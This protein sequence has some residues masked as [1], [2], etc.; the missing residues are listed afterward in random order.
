MTVAAAQPETPSLAAS[1]ASRRL[2]T[3]VL[4]STAAAALAAIVYLIA[5]PTIIDDAYIT[6]AYARNFGLHLHWG[7][8]PGLVD[9][10]ATSPLN[11]LVLALLTAVFRNALVALG[12]SVVLS[13][14]G[15]EWGLRRVARTAGLPPWTG[16]LATALCLLNP[17]VLSSLGMEILPCAALTAW[18]LVASVERR[19]WAF[20]LLAGLLAVLRADYVVIAA[21][22]FLFRSEFWVGAW[23]TI[24]AAIA[25]AA[26]WYVPSWILLGSAIPD[27]LVIK[28]LQHHWG[29]DTFGSGPALYWHVYPV[30]ALLAFGPAAAG[31]LAWAAWAALRGSFAGLRRLDLLAI[32]PVAAVIHYGAYTALGVPPYHWYYGPA[33]VLATMFLAGALAA[34]VASKP[35]GWHLA[36]RA[37]ATA[38]IVLL[39]GADIG[40]YGAPGLPRTYAP[41]TTNWASTA[42]YRQIGLQL[43]G[44]VR[45]QPIGGPPEVGV[46]DYYCDCNVYENFSD[47]GHFPAQLARYEQRIGPIG[48]AVM[49]ANFANLNRSIR[50]RPTRYVLQVEARPD[51]RAIRNWRISS[52]WMP[53]QYLALL[54]Q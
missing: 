31:V 37:G 15:L 20:G 18:L 12:L 53:A 16:L 35:Q 39:A 33:I 26:C 19:P 47:R 8:V 29:G 32:L 10:T 17:L 30:A 50:P 43:S 49:Q 46:I 1:S 41:I 38:A 22:V 2:R 14:V 24:G 44:L 6:L 23:K 34:A 36:L 51:R 52:P 7:L 40:A 45:N 4:F 21:V 48:K 5:S 54:R 25:A 28:S 27:T 42:Q 9:N 3:P 13:A 11:V